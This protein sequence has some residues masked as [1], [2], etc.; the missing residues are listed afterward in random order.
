MTEVELSSV[1]HNN[2]AIADSD[3]R[4]TVFGTLCIK[5]LRSTCIAIDE[6]K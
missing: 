5:G 2:T 6:L 3:M 4:S 1:L